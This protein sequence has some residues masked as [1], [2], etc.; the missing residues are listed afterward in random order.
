M[1]EDLHLTPNDELEQQISELFSQLSLEEKVSL[2]SGDDSWHTHPIPRL[3][4]PSLTMS[5]GPHG[6]R[7]RQPDVGRKA[8][9][10]TA[11]PTG[12]SL[13]S[14]WNPT[15]IEN[16]GA[17]L[18]EET[19]A[20]GCDILLGPNVNIIRTPLAGRNF[21]TYS[22]DPHLAG[23]IGAAWVRGLQSKGVGASVK[24]FACNNQEY[25]RDRGSSEVDERTLREIYLPAFETIVRQA[26]PWTV[27]CSYNRINGVYAS[28]N[29]YLLTQILRNEWGFLG[30]VISDWGANH[31][32]VESIRAGLDLEMPGPA[33]YYGRLLVEAVNNWQ[34]PME[35]IDRA[36]RRILRLVLL[37]GRAPVYK[38]ARSRPAGAVNTPEHTALARQVA[39]EAIVLLKNTPALLPLDPG[40][41]RTLAII[42]PNAADLALGGGGSAFVDPPYRISPLDG[43]RQLLG[44]RVQVDYAKGC[45]HGSSPTLIRAQFLKPAR[46]SGSGLWAEY[47]PNPDFSGEPSLAEVEP[48]LDFWWFLRGPAEDIPEVFSARYTGYLIAPATGSF[49]LILAN[50]GIARLFLDGRKILDS[51]QGASVYGNSFYRTQVRVDLEAGREYDLRV[52]FIRPAGTPI[53]QLRLEYRQIPLEDEQTLIAQAAELAGRADAAVVVVGMP[54]G[55]ETEGYDRPDMSLPGSQNELVQAVAQANPNTIVVINGSAPVEMP[56][57]DQTPAVLHAFYPGMEGGAALAR[58]LTGQV[59]PSGKLTLTLPRRY[60]DNPT[61]INY[62][63]SRRVF[64]GERIYVGYRYYDHKEIEPLFPF[65]HGL[66]YTTFEYSSLEL[67]EKIYTGETIPVSLTLRNTGRLAGKET[68]QLYVQDLQSSVDR[69]PK[70]LK[71]FAKVHLEPGESQAVHFVLTFR[72]LSYYD[73]DRQDWVA[74]PG[75]FRILVGSSSRDIRLSADFEWVG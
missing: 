73:V 39:E 58:I 45:Y 53:A 26:Q 8:S 65:G 74:E 60:T 23:M 44:E 30:A 19:L 56:W 40:K 21:E 25:E 70:E 27:M 72:D 75:Q 6:V 43:L 29:H 1:E 35:D 68:V 46:G 14:T 42:G 9:A 71:A 13:A 59:N 22:E 33:K 52:E 62:P 50:T 20:V 55:Y 15:L 16:V 48:C 24:H 32:T 66:S 47:F 11:F 4:L 69:P 64:Y 67:P 38:P 5:D 17:A 57:I 2:L 36:A 28:Q 12:I 3:N 63:G 31:T 18:A 10:T 51:Q 34:V 61:S 41:I 49:D 7:C 37:S 54:E